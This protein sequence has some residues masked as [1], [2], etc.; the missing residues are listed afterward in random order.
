MTKL[1]TSTVMAEVLPAI[2]TLINS[3]N[4]VADG[5]DLT[6]EIRRLL[7]MGV[8]RSALKW[9]KFEPGLF[10]EAGTVIYDLRH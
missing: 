1:N 7:D 3:L 4:K 10:D 2:L 9:L 8:A 6:I 5:K